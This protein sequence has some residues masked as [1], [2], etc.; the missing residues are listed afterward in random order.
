M[1]TARFFANFASGPEQ[2]AYMVN[3]MSGLLSAA[4]ILLLFWTITHLACKIVLKE[5]NRISVAQMIVVLGC[6]LVGS[7]AYAFSDTFWFSAVEGEVYAYSSFCTALVFWLILK[8][9]R[10]ADEP[11][12]DRYIVLIAYLIGVSIAVHLLNLLCIPAIVLVFYYR[13]FKNT[14]AKGSLIALILSFG[15]I[16]LLLYGLVPGFVKVAG[17]VELLFV[18]V[19][20]APYNTGVVVYFFVVIAAIVWGIYE[21]Y[22]QRSDKKIKLSFLVSV[23]LVGLPFIGNSIWLGIFLSAILAIYLFYF[24]KT[25]ALRVMNTIL[26]CIMVIFIGYSSYAL[27]VIRSSAN[28]PMDQNSPEDVFTLASYLNREQYGDRP[29]LY[30]NTFVSLVT[31]MALFW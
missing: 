6:G 12:S 18:N 23:M 9:E 29:L 22:K 20:H 1:L 28:T 5:E 25:V 15:I 7:L 14:N 27:I 17:W 4:T 21:T 13:K 30:G 31:E 24:Q 8:W 2:V 10:V 26:V 11:H 3:L 16:V 19:L